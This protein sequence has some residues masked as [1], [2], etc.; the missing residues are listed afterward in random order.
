[1]Y[2]IMYRLQGNRIDGN[3]DQEENN[4]DDDEGDVEVEESDPDSDEEDE[5]VDN[6]CGG[7]STLMIAEMLLRDFRLSDE[8]KVGGKI[9]GKVG[10]WALLKA[11]GAL[12]DDYKDKD[13][14]KRLQPKVE[15]DQYIKLCKRE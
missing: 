10:T 11:N 3:L 14:Y 5:E 7:L 1:M 4:E 9:N 8:T 15:D 2:K 12:E 13:W 6:S